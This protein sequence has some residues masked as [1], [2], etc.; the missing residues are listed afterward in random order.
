M[1]KLLNLLIFIFL[2]LSLI[3]Q[4]I[5]PNGYNIFYHANGV[6][7]SEGYLKDGKPDAYWKSY[8]E[9]GVLVSEGNRK[10]G[11]LDGEWKFYNSEGELYMSLNYKNDK[12]DGIKTTFKPNGDR[13]LESFIDDLKQGNEKHF[14]K[15]NHLI[16]EVP[17]VDG[18]EEGIAKEYDSEGTI[19]SILE[20]KRGYILRREH[21]NRKDQ[22]GLKQGLWKIFYANDILK[23]EGFYLNDKKDGFFKY[24]DEEGN[25]ISLEKYNNGEIV[26][27]VEETRVL[28][29]RVDYYKNGRQKVIQT[30]YKGKPHGVRREY[31]PKG[32]VVES[33]LFYEG[34][35][36]GIGIIDLDGKKQG[37]WKELYK[38]NVLKA[39]GNYVD[40]RPIGNWKYY[41]P[42][43]ELEIEGT[44]DKQGRRVGEWF[45]YYENSKPLR[46]A[47]YDLGK[48][49]GEFVEYDE[50]GNILSKGV[51]Q[52]NEQEGMWI[53][54]HGD[55][56]EEGKFFEGMRNGS[57]KGTY[58]NGNKSYETTFNDDNPDGSYK[59]YWFNGKLKESGRYI[60]GRKHGVWQYFDE[61]GE[62]FLRVTYRKGVE[63][64]YDNIKI[65]PEL[66]ETLED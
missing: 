11:F 34:E 43:G 32:E 49:E 28:E 56:V 36:L 31:S 17:F 3:S 61:S 45:W 57:W 60:L 47:N 15:D 19:I 14:D 59:S 38:R 53:E 22:S 1:K 12:K 62:M 9:K 33:Y 30:Y 21:I 4:T 27:G 66:P 20:Y 65:I 23:E 25:L 5:D 42:N 55:H 29:T 7:S 37:P 13:I 54:A 18:V 44:Y 63:I 51:Y 41:L 58:K 52:D 35:L 6:K 24:Y 48:L 10:D 40:S 64:S 2:S 8:N 50:D 39:E 16:K 26:E 46:E